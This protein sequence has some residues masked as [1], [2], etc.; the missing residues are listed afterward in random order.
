VG[1]HEKIKKQS[2]D[3]KNI[4]FRKIAQCCQCEESGGIEIAY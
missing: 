4:Q 1:T 3:L 2:T